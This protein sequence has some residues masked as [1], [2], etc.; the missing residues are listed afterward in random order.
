MKNETRKR[1]T[2]EFIISTCT[3]S[4]L[5]VYRVLFFK[6]STFHCRHIALAREREK[7]YI[8]SYLCII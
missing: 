6:F 5:N 2:L 4:F 8:Y 3:L 7:E 1:E